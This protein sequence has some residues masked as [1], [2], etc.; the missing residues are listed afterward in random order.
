MA[1]YKD[2][3]TIANDPNFQNR[4]LYALEVA[5]IAVMSE[6]GNADGHTRRVCYANAVLNNGVS[7]VCATRAILTNVA[8]AGEADI[9]QTTNGGYA[10]PDGDIQFAANT[11]F[12]A[13]SGVAN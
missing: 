9:S 3:I 2:L 13:L 12:S 10:I 6:A 5:S 4:V 7:V 8:I 1:S 11:L